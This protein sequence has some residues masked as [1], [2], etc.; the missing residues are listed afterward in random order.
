MARAATGD[1]VTVRAGNTVYTGLVIAATVA[2]AIAL[3]VVLVRGGAMGVSFF[4]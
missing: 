3:L 4:G 2:V 1:V